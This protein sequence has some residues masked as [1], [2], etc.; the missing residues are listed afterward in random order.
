MSIIEN[1]NKLLNLIHSKNIYLS[2]FSNILKINEFINDGI[3]NEL[4]I[5][6]SDNK[7]FININSSNNNLY[8][9]II[10]LENYSSI[11][12]IN[13]LNTK[14]NYI[15][16]YYNLPNYFLSISKAIIIGDTNIKKEETTKN[17]NNKYN[18]DNNKDLLN[19]L[20]E[21]D[22]ENESNSENEK[23]NNFIENNSVDIDNV[24]H[25]NKYLILNKKLFDFILI[26]AYE[27]DVE[28][29]VEDI[30]IPENKF[31]I[32]KYECLVI[33]SGLNYKIKNDNNKLIICFL[34]IID[35]YKQ[36]YDHNIHPN[37]V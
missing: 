7:F 12:L 30:F 18:D 23:I 26:I 3:I 1:K 14:L 4:K 13:Y 2:V 20:N 33:P 24:E 37:M 32:K 25:L 17:I 11:Y 16:N 15:E 22:S 19:L 36:K 28:N 31:N 29:V 9:E 21:L 10:L 35:G 34:N 8:N 5:S 6:K 27:N